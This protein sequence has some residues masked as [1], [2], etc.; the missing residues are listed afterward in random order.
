M[1]TAGLIQLVVISVDGA[2]NEAG[3]QLSSSASVHSNCCWENGNSKKAEHWE[4]I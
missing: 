4:L 2:G 3:A 1:N